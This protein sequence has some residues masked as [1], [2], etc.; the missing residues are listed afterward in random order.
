MIIMVLAADQGGKQR[1]S[2]GEETEVSLSHMET[3]LM[4]TSPE[5]IKEASWD[6]HIDPRRQDWSDQAEMQVQNQE[7]FLRRRLF[8][9][10]AQGEH[11]SQRWV[12]SPQKG[13]G[14]EATLQPWPQ[15]ML[16]PN[17]PKPRTRAQHDHVAAP[18]AHTKSP[19]SSSRHAQYH[20]PV[21]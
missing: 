16:L 12:S 5:D 17:K 4:V 10:K 6:F 1:E 13:Q 21:H 11:A 2:C 18:T 3:E 7:L 9:G 19:Q 20:K 15:V 8:P 14:T